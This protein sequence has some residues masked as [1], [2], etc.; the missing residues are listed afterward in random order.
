[1]GNNDHEKKYRM[2][3]KEVSGQGHLLKL[4]FRSLDL[5][6]GNIKHEN[7]HN[8]NIKVIQLILLAIYRRPMIS[9]G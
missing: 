6:F 7:Q 4:Q 3:L 8:T 9:A 5:L 1:M 2:T